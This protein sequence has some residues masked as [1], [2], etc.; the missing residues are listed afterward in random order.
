MAKI[1][2]TQ[3]AYEA[4][5]VIADAQRCVNLFPEKNP[6][7][8]AAPFT[9]YPTPGLTMLAAGPAN[10]V[11]G[12]YFASNNQLFA[13]IGKEVYYVGEDWSLTKLG[14]MLKDGQACVDMQDNTKTLVIVDGSEN[15]YTVDLASHAFSLLSD[16]TGAF[17]GANSVAYLD[18][19]LLFNFPGTRQFYTSLSNTVTFDASYYATKATQPDR[20]VAVNVKGSELW[21]VGQKTTE[22][23]YNAGNAT[24]PFAEITGTGLSVGCAAVFSIAKDQDSLYWL[25]R[26]D[27]GQACVVMT[28]GYDTK[29]ISTFALEAAWAEYS[30]IDDAVAFVYQS[31]GHTFYQITFPTANKTWVFDRTIGLWHQRAWMDDSGDLHRHRAQVFAYAYGTLVVGDFENGKLYRLDNQ[32]YTDDGKAILRLRSFPH[33]GDDGKR[34]VY[35]A[36]MADMEVGRGDPNLSPIVNLRWSDTRG[37]SWGQ[38]IQQTAGKA[39][40]FLT[41]ITWRRLGLARDRVFE[42][43]WSFPYKT[44]LNGAYVDFTACDS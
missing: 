8:A 37:V 34:I 15:G 25:S 31:G 38:P 5:S 7:G 17:V 40:E 10:P 13:V 26:D 2:L 43:S 6:E 23:W 21:L 32:A 28:A 39:G 27:R 1:A 44:A 12:L 42:L 11:R 16:S 33:L 18:G 35:H 3:G 24:F 41:A 36:F 30:K 20:L 19:F 22:V 29:K 4:R 9:L 14:T